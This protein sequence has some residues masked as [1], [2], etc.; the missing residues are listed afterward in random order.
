MTTPSEL[1]Y[2]IPYG[3]LGAAFACMYQKTNTI[4]T[5]ISMH[6]FH[7]SALILLSILI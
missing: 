4:F 6:M 3:G 7:N 5:D 1:L 2:I